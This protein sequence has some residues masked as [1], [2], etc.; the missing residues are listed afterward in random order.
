MHTTSLRHKTTKHWFDFKIMHLGHNL[1]KMMYKN[2]FVFGAQ[3]VIYLSIGT[4][5]VGRSKKKI[6]IQ[7]FLYKSFRNPLNDFQRYLQDHFLHRMQENDICFQIC[8]LKPND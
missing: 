5:S 1:D 2:H 4:L 7:V 8:S 6:C 3:L